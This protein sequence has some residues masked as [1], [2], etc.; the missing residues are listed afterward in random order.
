MTIIK[1]LFCRDKHVF[2]ATKLLP[3][4]K[5]LRQLLP[6]IPILS[7]A[8]VTGLLIYSVRVTGL[9]IYSVRVT[10]LL[11]YSVRVTGLPIFYSVRETGLPIFYSVRVTGLPTFY[12]VRVTGLPHQFLLSQGRVY[13]GPKDNN[14]LGEKRQ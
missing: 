9:L 2:V 1:D 6:M 11:I 13:I 12:S 14:T 7:S 3:R 10:G 8:T 5:Y 4:R